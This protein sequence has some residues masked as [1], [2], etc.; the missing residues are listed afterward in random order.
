MTLVLVGMIVVL[1][2]AMS[3]A[4]AQL[5]RKGDPQSQKAG[6]FLAGMSLLVAGVAVAMA[7]MTVVD[8]MRDHDR[9]DQVEAPAA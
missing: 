6:R 9:D 4:S 3:V 5:A 8:R 2:A 7:V 1:A